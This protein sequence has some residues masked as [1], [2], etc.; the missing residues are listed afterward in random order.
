M[1]LYLDTSSLVK[2]YVE[3]V[4]TDQV[5]DA[6]GAANV[7][8]TSR[9]AFPEAMAAFGRRLREKS[10]TREEF[11]GIEAAFARDWDRVAVLDLDERAAGALAVRHGLRG[12]DAIHL[13]AALAVRK[14]A[15]GTRL[16]FSSFD[17]ALNAAA[18][19]EGLEVFGPNEF[20]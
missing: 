16:A 20:K 12:F 2:L 18:R 19:R 5:R 15:S 4:G 3:E 10:L 8:A 11:R 14:Q 13:E 9:V 1:I 7:V 17:M 6:V